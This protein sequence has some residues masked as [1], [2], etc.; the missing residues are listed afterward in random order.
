MNAL[1]EKNIPTIDEGIFSQ[2][3]AKRIHHVAE[4]LNPARSTQ[5]SAGVPL[6][7]SV[8]IALGTLL[9]VS[10]HVALIFFI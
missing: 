9:S 10:Y 1:Y 6:H 8:K 3:L 7:E 4:E 5:I 2:G